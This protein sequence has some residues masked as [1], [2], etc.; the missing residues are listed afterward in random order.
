MKTSIFGFLREPVALV[1]GASVVWAALAVGVVAVAPGASAQVSG[2]ALPAS[3]G[4]AAK[5]VR[6]V[7]GKRGSH[8]REIALKDEIFQNERIETGPGGAAVILLRDNTK[9]SLGPKSSLVLDEFVFDPMPNKRKVVMNAVSGVFRFVSGNSPS[10]AYQVKSGSATLGIRGTSFNLIVGFNGAVTVHVTNGAVLFS[11]IAGDSVL[12]TPGLASTIFAPEPGGNQAKPSEPAEPQAAV[13]SMVQQIDTS[14]ATSEEASLASLASLGAENAGGEE[15][16]LLGLGGTGPGGGPGGTGGAVGEDANLVSVPAKAILGALGGSDDGMKALQEFLQGDGADPEVV[17]KRAISLLR[18]LQDTPAAGNYEILT[19]AAERI[20]DAA[21]NVFNTG[22][23]MRLTIDAD[24]Q[25]PDGSFA[26]D[27]QPPDGNLGGGWEEI[28]PRDERVAGQDLRGLSRPGGDPVTADG[29]LGVEEFNV[30]VP[31]NMWRVIVMTEDL[32]AGSAGGEEVS[33]FGDVMRINDQSLEFK[34]TKPEDWSNTAFLTN[35]I[36]DVGSFKSEGAEMSQD[37][38]AGLIG[39]ATT[40]EAGVVV[41]ETEALNNGINLQFVNNSGGT[42]RR[43]YVVG[44]LVEPIEKESSVRG[45]PPLAR[46]L[47]LESLINR[48]LAKILENVDPAA[49]DVDVELFPET[50]ENSPA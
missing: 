19:K 26:F 12:V 39:D 10:R 31:N 14:L 5:V 13:D 1:L 48:E 37:E 17:T 6:E 23:V 7:Q 2:A 45:F 40:R 8:V 36:L 42:P 47:E 49:G 22:S 29:I 3:I 33:Y 25:K 34:K 30:N 43:T 24:Y 21:S 4:L 11:N 15:G 20:T 9:I 50:D 35:E 46:F 27:L 28:L 16:G 44:V 41:S 38:I 18:A 32:G